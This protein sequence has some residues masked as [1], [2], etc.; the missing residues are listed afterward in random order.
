MT[1][2]TQTVE[3]VL[4]TAIR[5][6][7]RSEQIYRQAAEIVSVP[8]AKTLLRELAEEEVRHK[9]LLEGVKASGDH[10]RIGHGDA[11]TDMKLSDYLKEIPL[12][13]ESTIEDIFVFA[14]KRE[15]Q[16]V[17]LYT[18]MLDIYAGTDATPIL[19][20]L[21]LEEQGHKE[22]LEKEY[23]DIIIHDN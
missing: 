3:A 18:R 9:E 10:Q 2:N 19:K 4:D 6:E 11:P 1:E 21:V 23:D 22:R 14:M 8:G 20:R 12:T 16:A 5:L 7:T 13:N 15:Q 17:D